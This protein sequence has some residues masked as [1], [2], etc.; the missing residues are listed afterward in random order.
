M[1]SFNTSKALLLVDF[2]NDIIHPQGKLVSKGYVDF[3]LR[4][5]TLERV[6]K[7]LVHAR[8]QQYAV[9]HIGIG[10]S[11]DYKEQPENSLLFGGAKKLEAFKLGTWGAQFHAKAAPVEGE[12]CLTKHRVSAFYGTALDMILRTYGVKSIVVAGCATDLAVQST[13]REAHD[14]DYQCT[15]IGDCCIA[16]NDKDHEDALRLLSKPSKVV[17]LH[18]LAIHVEPLQLL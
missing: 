7:L 14:R 17:T 16:A 15:V 18:E 3:E 1:A 5:G 2:I 11:S 6:E 13:V 9:I 8:S 4:H 10:F 12:A